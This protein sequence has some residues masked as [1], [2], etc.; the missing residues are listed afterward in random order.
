MSGL[1]PAVLVGS[2]VGVVVGYAT[3]ILSAKEL[4]RRAR[5]DAYIGFTSAALDAVHRKSD[6]GSW[7][8]LEK[9]Y[10]HLCLVATPT[11][12][13]AADSVLD[14]ARSG[15]PSAKDLKSFADRVRVD[16]NSWRRG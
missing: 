9:A 12:C 7:D 5:L 4:R 8:G 16:T 10:T 14:S 15:E 11:G 1:L 3:S 13:A 6:H 2:F